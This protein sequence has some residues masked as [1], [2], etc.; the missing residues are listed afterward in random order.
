[1]YSVLSTLNLKLP[2]PKLLLKSTLAIVVAFLPI[3]MIGYFF[4]LN[5]VFPTV[6]SLLAALSFA[7]VASN[8]GIIKSIILLALVTSFS[9]YFEGNIY[10]I[11]LVMTI[12]SLLC[13]I[14]NKW[15]SSA[16]LMAPII[17]IIFA[18]HS[19]D[20]NPI[21]AG[22]W[23]VAGGLYGAML[24]KLS[25]VML[26]PKL[27]TRNQVI[28][29]GIVLAVFCVLI[30]WAVVKYNLPHG[31]WLVVTLVVVLRPTARE[32]DKMFWRRVP[33]TLIGA[34][35]ATI[36]AVI[37]PYPWIILFALV[38]AI[39]LFAYALQ[40]NYFYK[41]L[42]MTPTLILFLSAGSGKVA[43]VLALERAIWTLIGA[44]IAMVLALFL[45]KLDKQ[46][47]D[48]S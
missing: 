17:V 2:S 1:M 42:F 22:L 10:G 15:S 41:T 40:G 26:K 30:T 45:R 19:I 34:I 21:S 11:L 39:M 16:L 25:K 7:T 18:T 37:I 47:I 33:G 36:M 35:I 5:P 8:K 31:Y 4:G 32:S 13:A 23:S 28:R 48:L 46:P 27:A 44:I 9:V 24:I 29:Y 43:E 6:L 12:S 20:I 38:C 14:A 3:V